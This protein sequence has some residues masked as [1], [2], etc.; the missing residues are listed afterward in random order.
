ML[1]LNFQVNPVP[2]SRPRVTRWGC[3]YG[4]R[5]SACRAE[6]CSLL[7]N[8]RGSE[9]LPA[10]LCGRLIVWV[11]FTISKPRVTKLLSPRGDVDNYVKLLFDC[12]N[13]RIWK[14]DTQVEI[15]SVRKRWATNSG[16]TDVWIKEQ[17]D[18]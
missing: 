11:L 18:G 9:A 15:M 10:I 13:E 16:C 12:F 17:S 2:A 1:Y 14:D 4:K 3:Y 5:H 7:D 8:M 6:L